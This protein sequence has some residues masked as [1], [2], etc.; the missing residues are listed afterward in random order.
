MATAVLDLLWP[1]GRAPVGATR[2]DPGL[3]QVGRR[4]R[5]AA[6]EGEPPAGSP[7]GERGE[8]AG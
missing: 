1:P 2:W 4:P 3:R 7:A 8:M 5:R 6:A